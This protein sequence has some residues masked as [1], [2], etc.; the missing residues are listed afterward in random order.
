MRYLKIIAIMI[1]VAIAF[2]GCNLTTPVS[3]SQ[4]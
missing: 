3:A 2:T 4:R 1:L